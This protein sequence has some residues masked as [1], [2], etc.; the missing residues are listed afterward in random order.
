MRILS[1]KK[2]IS[3]FLIIILMALSLV[4]GALISYM[5]VIADFYWEARDTTNLV[6]TEAVFPNNDADHFY[7]TIMNPSHSPSDASVVSIYFTVEGNS[8]VFSVT[9]TYPE[10][11]PITI[12]KGKSK[13]VRCDENWGKFAGKSI[14]VSIV[15]ESGSGASVS[16]KTDFVK[17]EVEAS[18][19]PAISCKHFNVT[20]RNN[21]NSVISLRVKGIAINL[22]PVENVKSLPDEQNVTFPIN[23]PKGGSLQLKCIFNW[24]GF[25]NPKIR[26]ETVEGYIVETTVNTNA[27][28][29]LSI[30]NVSFNESKSDELSI[31]VYNSRY[32]STYVDILNVTLTYVNGTS[33]VT[34]TING[35]NTN[36][37][38]T[39]YYR[40]AI[41]GT[42]TFQHCVWNWTNF[43][44][45]NVTVTIYTKQEF[46]PA[47]KTVKTPSSYVFEITEL[48]FNLTNTTRF[49]VKIAN[50][51]CS[52]DS[53]NV[54]RIKFGN[55]TIY[56]EP[57]I[58]E[59]GEEK[60]LNCTF[61]WASFR[62]QNVSIM[63]LTSTDLSSPTKSI[64]LPRFDGKIWV[65]A[66]DFAK[67]P[68]G[69]PYVNITVENTIYS[70][71]TIKIIQ[72]TFKVGDISH[73]ID[74]T[75]TNPM[76]IP[77]GY[78]LSV[79]A[80]VT[81]TCPWGWVLYPNQYL[82]ITVYT[83]EGCTISQ[84]FQ[85]PEGTP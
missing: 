4:A 15:P 35:S 53:I 71:V 59:R 34:Y 75:S 44:N 50:R 56:V 43:R 45:Q 23:L 78:T 65:D 73:P 84:T 19:N 8:T 39:P 51:L 2:A 67:S 25:L 60:I 48:Y 29:L 62:G 70:N 72:I 31:T 1:N 83:A 69:V 80:N 52:V 26:V 13:T 22:Y 55:E 12:E 40:L 42:V 47:S 61:N 17:L 5:L 36:P 46:T 49:Q 11:L 77:N 85:I 18:V 27:S 33:P 16:V 79:G 54:T 82:T 63:A 57:Q 24:E 66:S 37:P 10:S 81:I 38:F 68:E 7:L 58:I 9:K 14:T 76:L 3:T 64:I 6:I 32:S 30:T 41:N 74:G 21:A 20:V 28:V